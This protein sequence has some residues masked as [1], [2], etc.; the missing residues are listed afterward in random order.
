MGALR[1]MSDMN[2]PT[3]ITLTAY[4]PLALPASYALG[5]LFDL[6]AVG[7]WIGYTLGLVVAAVALPLRFWALTRT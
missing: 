3:I 2:L 1:G 4:W 6:G 5:F 7:V